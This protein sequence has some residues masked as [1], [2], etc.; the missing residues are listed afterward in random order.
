MWIWVADPTKVFTNLVNVRLAWNYL[1][2]ATHIPRMMRLLAV[3]EREVIM[4]V[5]SIMRVL[6]KCNDNE[7]LC[8]AIGRSNAIVKALIFLLFARVRSHILSDNSL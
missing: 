5:L 1:Q 8:G 4:D 7:K 6:T 2:L 3:P